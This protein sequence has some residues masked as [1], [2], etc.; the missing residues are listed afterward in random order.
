[1]KVALSFPGCHRR[2]GV[3]RVVFECAGYLAQRGH[4]VTV[5]ADEWEQGDTRGVSYRRVAARRRPRWLHGASY[6]KECTKAM[7]QADFDVLNTHGVVCPTGGVQWV[8]SVHC[9]WLERCKEFRPLHSL[10]R[11]K[12]ALNPLHPVILNLE[13]RHFRERRYQRLIATTEAVR[14]DLHRLYDVPTGDV[15]VIPNGFSPVEFNPTRRAA[16]RVAMRAKLGLVEREIAL[17]FVANELDRKGFETVLE[18]LR[19][20]QAPRLR[21]LTVGRPASESIRQR[22]ERF[23]VAHQVLP[24]GATSDIGAFH[25]AGDLFVLPTQYEAFSL[26]ILEAL[27]SG[28]PVITSNV[29]GA[30]DAI[31]PGINGYL[32]EDPKS[33]EELAAIIRPLL[34]DEARA[35]LTSQVPRT[36]EQYQWPNVLGRYERVLAQFARGGSH[37]ET[38]SQPLNR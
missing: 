4:A 14:Q 9:A 21:L 22:A 34:D 19:I 37:A 11:W 7:V 26:A 15:E 12:Q 38:D 5:F 24:C 1:M 6:F 2:A 33:G 27:G 10:G 28:L 32:M 3:E 30:H 29:P 36:S 13:R 23:G 18:A 31:R 16:R 35:A 8:Q 25:A 20:L 17:L